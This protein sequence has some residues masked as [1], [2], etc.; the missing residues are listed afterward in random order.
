MENLEKRLDEFI[1]K[2]TKN[3]EEKPI[4]TIIKSLVVIWIGMKVIK[5]LKK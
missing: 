3:L 1:D 2:F 5:M 4:N